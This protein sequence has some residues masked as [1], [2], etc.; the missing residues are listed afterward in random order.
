MGD[1]EKNGIYI[2]TTYIWYK[3]AHCRGC[4]TTGARGIVFSDVRFIWDFLWSHND[5]KFQTLL[6]QI[7]NYKGNYT[8]ISNDPFYLPNWPVLPSKLTRFN[9]PDDPFYH[10]VWPV[11]TIQIDP[12]YH[13]V[14]PVLPFKLTRLTFSLTRL[15]RGTVYIYIYI[16]IY[17]A[18][19][20]FY[21]KP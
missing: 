19:N 1:F 14:W 13:P 16:Y 7:C 6:M 11:L 9:I 3:N 4:S 12:F 2:Y 8:Y 18:L 5:E 15:P 10:P 20:W 21:M 17:M